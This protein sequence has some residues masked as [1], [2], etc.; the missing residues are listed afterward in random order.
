M[1]QARCFGFRSS[2]CRGRI[3]QHSLG[4]FP[5]GY[6]VEQL[7]LHDNALRCSFGCRFLRRD[8]G[9]RGQFQLMLNLEARNRFVDGARLGLFSFQRE[10]FDALLLIKFLLCKPRPVALGCRVFACR[11]DELALVLFR[12][13][14]R[15][16]G[17]AARNGASGHVA[18]VRCRRCACEHFAPLGFGL[19]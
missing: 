13:R 4:F 7:S 8:A 17:C 11:R 14:W 10:C 12:R 15:L 5:F 2:S 3:A 9:N 1:G 6:D 18:R 16:A 19:I